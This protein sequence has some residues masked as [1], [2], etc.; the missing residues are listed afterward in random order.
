MTDAAA[1]DDD[2]LDAIAAGMLADD[3]RASEEQRK[4]DRMLDDHIDGVT[5]VERD[6]A[7]YTEDGRLYEEMDHTGIPGAGAEFLA[8]LRA[9]AIYAGERPPASL[10]E[11]HSEMARPEVDPSTDDHGSPALDPELQRIVDVNK[12]N[13]LTP[14][15]WSRVRGKHA[16]PEGREYRASTPEQ[17]RGLDLGR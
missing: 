1:S 15:A 10:A 6:G 16:A 11:V 3:F 4:F 12:R 13:Y 5:Y 2:G 8:E 7:T 14:A 17:S 9:K